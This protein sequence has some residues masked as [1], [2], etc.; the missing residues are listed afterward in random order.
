MPDALVVIPARLAST[1][2]ERKLLLR[3]TGRTV[4][5]HTWERVR[6]ARRV[7][8]VVIACDH[9]ELLAAAREFGGEALLTRADHPS[10]TDRVA[11][12]ARV[13][14]GRGER[15]E[16]VVNVQG[17]EPELDPGHVDRLIELMEE[18]V[19]CAMGT[20]AEPITDPADHARPQVV[21][22]VLDGAGRALY[23]SR[24]PIPSGGPAEAAASG[25][26]LGLR[27][28]G[29]YA[30]RPDFLQQYCALPPAPLERRE[31]LE[32]LRAL[33]HGHAIRVAV[34]EAQGAVGIDTPEDYA[35]F[36]SRWREGAQG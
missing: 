4:L 13:L 3:D 16:L 36:V 6:G 30:Y 25:T 1:R 31:R 9:D 8:R 34:V 23:F 2:L 14:A 12:A 20:L 26:P 17:D 24:A 15:F 19:P 35:R 11:E 32:Q 5:Q 18:P 33:H 10:G 21:K 29:I 7:A 22:V 28:V 27:H